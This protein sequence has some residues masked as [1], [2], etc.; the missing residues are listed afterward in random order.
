M[1]LPVE[2]GCKKF[3]FIGLNLFTFARQDALTVMIQEKITFE[4]FD[5]I[6][7]RD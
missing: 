7:Y 5:G 6:F 1:C 2:S 4:T 3:A